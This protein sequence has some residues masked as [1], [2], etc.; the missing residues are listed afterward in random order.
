MKYFSFYWLTLFF[1]DT[2]FASR[3]SRTLSFGVLVQ[4][5]HILPGKIVATVE[6]AIQQ[7]LELI[8]SIDLAIRI[9][10][11]DFIL[12]GFVRLLRIDA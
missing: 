1:P 3:G 2:P 8:E 11:L 5:L 7:A 9:H 4:K 10:P 6:N 12:A